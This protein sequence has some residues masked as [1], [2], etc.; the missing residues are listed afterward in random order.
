MSKLKV[1]GNA[2][3]TGVVT[4][5]APNTNTD[6]TITLPDG[7]ISLGVGIDDN[8]TST[9]ITIDASENVGIGGAIV[10]TRKLTISKAGAEGVEFNLANAPN[11]NTIIHYNRS[12]TAY[13]TNIVN[14]ADHRF[15][16]QGAEKVRF[17]S[18]GGITFNGDTAAANA[19]D[20]YEEGTWTP[21]FKASD[22]TTAAGYS[23]N[24]YNYTKIGNTCTIYGYFHS[25]AWASITD[26]S[27]FGLQG[28][29]FTPSGYAGVAFVLS[30][31]N[32]GGM[33]CESGAPI[34]L[35]TNKD[36]GGEFTISG[37]DP[38]GNRMMMSF[39]YHTT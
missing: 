37:S 16:I 7:D 23:G 35:F 19:L 32:L 38:T 13:V 9:A 22:G 26:G 27:Y 28:L 36:T 21:V 1:S 12:G 17:P 20:D 18:T 34:A 33:Y 5:E 24:S 6:R 11:E 29:P 14:A 2:S 8:A 3:G 30:Q 4:I 39:T 15:Q 10:G 25:I 31:G